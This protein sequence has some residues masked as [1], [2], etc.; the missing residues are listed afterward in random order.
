MRRGRWSKKVWRRRG[1]LRPKRGL[2]RLIIGIHQLHHMF[3]ESD[4][5]NDTDI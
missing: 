3:L 1:A 2:L 5:A 4:M